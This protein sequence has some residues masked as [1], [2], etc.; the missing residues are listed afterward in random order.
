MSVIPWGLILSVGL[1][2][3]DIFFSRSAKKEAMKKQMFEFV[4][5][6]DTGVLNN[7]KIKKQYDGLLKQMSED[8]EKFKVMRQCFQSLIVPP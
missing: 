1:K 3:A 5:K 4:K 8:R 6:Y 7:V 2:L